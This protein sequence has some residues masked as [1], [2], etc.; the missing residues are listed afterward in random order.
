MQIMLNLTIEEKGSVSPSL[1]YLPATMFTL[2]ANGSV[3]SDATRTDKL[4]SYYTVK[5][6]LRRG[7][8]GAT[9]RYSRHT[10]EGRR[11]EID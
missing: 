11:P 6:L 2:G 7:P 4:N 1:D 3:S 5:E 8:C 9:N 10:A